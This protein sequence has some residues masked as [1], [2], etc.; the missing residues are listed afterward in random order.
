MSVCWTILSGCASNDDRVLARLVAEELRQNSKTVAVQSSDGPSSPAGQTGAEAPAEPLAPMRALTK[1]T[2][3]P[4][5]VIEISVAEDTT[6]GGTYE[7]NG[8]SAIS[9][10]Y[11]G[12]VFLPNMTEEQAAASIKHTLEE[13]GFRS[14]TV[15]VRIIKASYDMVRITGAVTQPSDLKIGPGS[16]ILM[17]EA[18]RRAGTLKTQTKGAKVKIVR[19]GL[20][21]PIGLEADGEEY[22]LV[23]PDGKA[24]IPEV[25][26]H[27]TDWAHVFPGDEGT[28]VGLGEKEILVLGEV[29]QPGMIRFANSEACTMMRLLFKI[30]LSRWADTRNVLVVRKGPEGTEEKI[31]VDVRRILQYGDPNDDIGLENGDRV[32]VKERRIF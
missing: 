12:M 2:V 18:L 8:S 31:N 21:N 15:Q 26:L 28:V 6:L 13:R 5:S 9:F 4:E 25:S 14:A 30:S 10:G 17:R 29:S 1:L 16:S 24:S 3:Q 11:V 19:G 20:R 7:V 22:S 32:I 27:G 23:G